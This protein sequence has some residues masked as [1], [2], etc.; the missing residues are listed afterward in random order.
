M[1]SGASSLVMAN[2]GHGGTLITGSPSSQ[3]QI[4]S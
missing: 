3:T 4:L 1:T 2:D